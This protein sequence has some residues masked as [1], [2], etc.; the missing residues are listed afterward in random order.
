MTRAPVIQ[1][2]IRR[3]MNDSFDILSLA[4]LGFAPVSDLRA[5]PVLKGCLAVG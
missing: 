3:T 4:D 1:A 2:G 5:F